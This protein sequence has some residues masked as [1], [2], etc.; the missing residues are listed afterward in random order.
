MSHFSSTAFSIQFSLENLVGMAPDGWLNAYCGASFSKQ[1][2]FSHFSFRFVNVFFFL[3]DFCRVVHRRAA[4]QWAFEPGDN[5]VKPVHF[6]FYCR[7]SHWGLM[8]MYIPLAVWPSWSTWSLSFFP[9]PSV[10]LSQRT[11]ISF[12]FFLFI[13]LRS[14]L[15]RNKPQKSIKSTWI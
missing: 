1:N 13:L 7:S 5:K 4:H 14:C 11:P 8:S 12:S 15:T 10:F 6:C 2:T 3:N 9:Y